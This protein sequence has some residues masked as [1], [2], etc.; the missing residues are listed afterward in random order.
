MSARLP[1][2]ERSCG[3]SA[4][5]SSS[6]VSSAFSAA[7]LSSSAR[8]MSAACW[9]A[10]SSAPCAVGRAGPRHPAPPARRRPAPLPHAHPT[11][12][13]P[14]DH[15]IT[16][17]S[18]R[19]GARGLPILSRGGGAAST[20]SAKPTLAPVGVS[21]TDCVTGLASGVHATT[22][23]A[24][25]GTFSRRKLPSA[26]HL[27]VVT[28]GD[29]QDVRPHLRVH[30]AEHLDDARRE[31]ADRAWLLALLV[32]AE[33]ERLRRRRRED[34]VKKRIGVG[35]RDARSAL[36]D[37]RRWGRTSDRAG[38]SPRRD[39]RRGSFMLST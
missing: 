38:R 14:P 25:T 1:S 34:V 29:D 9:R 15:R 24:P 6:C 26:A 28:V 16:Y 27:R 36:D 4:A 10:P 2:A 3:M 5:P 18:D 11:D 8:V 37:E 22:C 39:R 30:V 12:C 17:S 20:C 19:Y 35:E 33:V 32:A 7:M 31:Q 23:R 21:A 13:S